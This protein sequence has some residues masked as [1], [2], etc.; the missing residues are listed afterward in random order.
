MTQQVREGIRSVKLNTSSN[1]ITPVKGSWTLAHLA[2][3]TSSNKQNMAAP[4]DRVDGF[5][6]IVL[7]LSN[8]N[9]PVWNEKIYASK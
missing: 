7:I 6:K 9:I 4:I 5:K 8:V 1:Q 3:E 2:H